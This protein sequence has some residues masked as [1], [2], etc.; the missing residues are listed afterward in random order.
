MLYVWTMV[1]LQIVSDMGLPSQYRTRGLTVSVS[2]RQEIH[3]SVPRSLAARL[4]VGPLP[5]RSVVA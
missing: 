5:G 1:V 2:Y 4:R 3:M